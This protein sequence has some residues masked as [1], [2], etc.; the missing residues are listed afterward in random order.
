MRQHNVIFDMD[1]NKVGFAHAACNKDPNQVLS[2]LDMIENGQF[3][4]LDPNDKET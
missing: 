4:A 2:E 3:Y 1:N